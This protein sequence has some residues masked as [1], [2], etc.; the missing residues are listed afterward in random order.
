MR[1]K[2]EGQL[3]VIVNMS[4]LITSESEDE[5]VGRPSSIISDQQDREQSQPVHSETTV[6]EELKNIKVVLDDLGKRLIKLERNMELACNSSSSTTH[7]RHRSKEVPAQVRVS[8]MYKTE[9]SAG[10]RAFCAQNFIKTIFNLHDIASPVLQS[11]SIQVQFE[12]Y[13][14]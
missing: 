5:S 6:L 2:T 7:K 4:F 10:R 14:C 11:L 3:S 12:G 8:I 9:L 13:T 1:G